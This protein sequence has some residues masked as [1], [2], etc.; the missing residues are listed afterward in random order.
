MRTNWQMKL[1]P[2]RSTRRTCDVSEHG[3]KSDVYRDANQAQPVCGY[4]YAVIARVRTEGVLNDRSRE[5][6]P[7][8]Q[9]N[10]TLV[11]DFESVF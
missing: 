5:S 10:K 6:L 1:S 11:N 3:V 8:F 7:A 2:I 9:W 4:Q